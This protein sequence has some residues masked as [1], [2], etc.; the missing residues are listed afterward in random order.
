MN[1]TAC[2]CE[3]GLVRITTK[4]RDGYSEDLVACEECPLGERYLN[5]DRER[6]DE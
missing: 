3:D 2:T 6:G 1:E 5:D 4:D